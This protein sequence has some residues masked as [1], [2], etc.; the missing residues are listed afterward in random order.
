[1][2]PKK[3]FAIIVLC[4]LF[5][6]INLCA[7]ELPDVSRVQDLPSTTPV[8]PR[9]ERLQPLSI[10]SRPDFLNSA[11]SPT[12]A[13]GVQA[14]QPSLANV[15]S[16]PNFQGSFVSRGKTWPFTMM[17]GP[18]TTGVTTS[19]PVHI[20]AVSLKLQNADLVTFTT[21]PVAAFET[22]TLKSPNFQP[23]NYSSGAAIQFAD[24]VQR[25]EFFHVMKSTWHTVLHPVTIVHS[26][27]ITVPRFTS[28]VLNGK[29]TQV[30]TYF[31]SKS[32][33]GH[34]VVFVLDQF[35]NL[36]MFNLGISEIKAGRF[37]TGGLNMALLP[38]TFLFAVNSTGGMGSCCTIGFHTFFTNTA[39]KQSRWVFAFASWISPGI[40]AGGL[41]DI[42]TLSHEIS[43]SFNDPFLANLVPAWQFPNEP[44]SCQDNLEVGDPVEVLSN[45]VFPVHVLGVTYHPQTE[46]LLQW[47]KQTSPST[48]LGGAFSYPNT[49]ALTAPAIPFGPLTCP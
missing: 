34:T 39:T 48:A 35:F 13:A 26:V 19:I 33:D 30:R 37:I 27:T 8:V 41:Q 16:V 45:A 47:F 25:A 5:N 32:S 43:E 36:Q 23:A 11:A 9:Y 12:F 21:V 1:V 6:A 40:F 42:T 38:N 15:I 2:I 46:A 3:L 7:Q 20:V 28:V 29:S 24:A 17:G 14:P 18:P 44:G 49:K 22:P 10:E 31:T 4:L